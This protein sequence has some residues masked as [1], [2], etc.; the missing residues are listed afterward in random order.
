M[1]LTLKAG[2]VSC[3]GAPKMAQVTGKDAFP[4]DGANL[5]FL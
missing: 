5:E 1:G 2:T 3:S 4:K